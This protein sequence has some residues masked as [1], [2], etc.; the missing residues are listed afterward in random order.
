M[1]VKIP[2]YAFLSETGKLINT[3]ISRSIILSGNIYDLFLPTSSDSS[4]T[5]SNEVDYIPLVPF[6]CQKWN[7]PGF[8]LLVYELNGPIRFTS[9]TDRN[10]LKAA[11]GR[12]KQQTDD[13]LPLLDDPQISPQFDEYLHDATGN[14]TV[15]LEFL[16][17]LCMLSRTKGKQPLLKEN[18]LILIEA[19]DMLLPEGEIPRLSAADRHRVSIVQDW[20][21]DPAFINAGDAVIFIAESRSLVNSQI[22]RLPQVVSV[23]IPAP[24]MEARKHFISWF[25]QARKRQDISTN[26]GKDLHLWGTQ[27]QLA[28]LTAGLTLHAL[29]QLLMLACYT[30]EK[31]QPSTVIDKVADFIQSQLGED[32]V[33]F[34]KPGHRLK[35]VV[36]NR[37]LVA[38]L[39][40]KLRPRIQ[41]TGVDAIAGAAV[42]GPIGCGKTFIFEGLAG[43]LDMPVLVLKNIRSQWFGQTD[44]IF[45]RLRRLLMVLVK[46]MIFVDEA[47]TQF[48]GVD[49]DAHATERRLTG[50]IQA[51]MSDPQLRGHITWLLMTARIYNLSPDLRREGRVGDLIIPV[52]D[53]EGED[54][55]AFIRWAVSDVYGHKLDTT[56]I[57]KLREITEGYSAASFASL[58]SDL[59][60]EA[61][62]DQL[63]LDQIIEVAEDRIL[64]N[65]GAI[66]HYQ[67]LQALI[68]CTRKSLLPMDYSHELREKWAQEIRLLEQNGMVG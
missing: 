14:S 8:I 57:D 10:R 50:K 2:K 21:L 6:L 55:E 61:K 56:V 37:K 12:W 49:K 1:A 33:E 60:A 46:A 35:D 34:K 3:G 62:E 23:D 65:V 32:V 30:G 59:R 39:R 19:A 29:R 9:E 40:E 44:V 64:P 67:T 51:M 42:G 25:N 41:S 20:F 36:G 17:Q 24:D 18:L 47:D 63:T 22:T 68:N 13:G 54:R 66:R 16:R 26:R 53:P 7:V 38:F 31:L 52:L 45:E 58:R 43:D 11:Y 48:G 15:A 28:L 27:E 5:A 4:D